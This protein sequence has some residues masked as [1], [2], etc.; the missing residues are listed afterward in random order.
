MTQERASGMEGE[1]VRFEWIDE[2]NRMIDETN[3]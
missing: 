1:R 2:T 3:R